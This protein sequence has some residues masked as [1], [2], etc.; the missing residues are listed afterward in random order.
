M[1]LEEVGQILVKI[2]AYTKMTPPGK[3]DVAAWHSLPEIRKMR[4][5]DAE[6]AVMI[7]YQQHKSPMAPVDLIQ[8]VRV[9]PPEG[10]TPKG[11]FYG[12]PGETMCV[13]CHGVHYPNER[14]DVLVG[15]PDWF[16]QRYTAAAKRVGIPIPEASENEEIPF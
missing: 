3:V 5:A 2:A 10:A 11:P 7:Y 9:L 8:T 12:E 16:R 14:C 4:Y 1:N 6:R 15:M 13:K